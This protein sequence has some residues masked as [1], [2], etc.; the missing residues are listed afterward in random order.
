MAEAALVN[1]IKDLTKAVETQ[2][3]KMESIDGSLMK[4]RGA[5]SA[6]NDNYIEVNRT[7]NTTVTREE[8]PNAANS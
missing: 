7:S 6:M 1:A 5:L 8:G 3:R 2:T 4:I